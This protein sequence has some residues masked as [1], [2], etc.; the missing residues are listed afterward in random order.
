MFNA[1]TGLGGWV[2]TLQNYDWKGRPLVT[3]NP[4]ITGNPAD[5]TTKEASYIGC[6]C[7][8]GEVVTITDEGTIDAGVPKRRQQK[9]YSDILGRTVKTEVLNWQGGGVYSATV[10]TYNARDQVTRIRQ[11]QG[12]APADPNDLSCPSGTCQQ[13]TMDYDG[14]GRLEI[15]HL[16]EQQI[17]PNNSASTDH[18]KW[19]YNP[20]DTVLKVTD[21]RG[22]ERN[23]P[24][25]QP[26]SGHRDDLQRT[27]RASRRHRMSR[28]AMTQLETGLR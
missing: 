7:A 23:L 26:P 13:S 8:G 20:D 6:G 18:T 4:S 28:S 14:H 24:L 10:N 11:F 9:I 21:A 2:Y 3:T 19:E 27:R 1:Q 22:R 12:T 16:P 17:D 25:Q 15:R 5:T